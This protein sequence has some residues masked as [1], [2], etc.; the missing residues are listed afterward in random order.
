[1]EWLRCQLQLRLAGAHVMPKA[2]P[3]VGPIVIIGR[4]KVIR[5]SL[6]FCLT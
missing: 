6:P 1:L 4:D 2:P 3:I 5:E